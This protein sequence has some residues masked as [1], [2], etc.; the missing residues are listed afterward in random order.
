MACDN[1]CHESPIDFDFAL[2]YFRRFSDSNGRA[3]SP[4]PPGKR[5]KEEEEVKEEG[6]EPDSFDATVDDF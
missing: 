6:K 4:S 2:L 1:L 3:C 5:G